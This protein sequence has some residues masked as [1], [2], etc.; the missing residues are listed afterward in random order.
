MTPSIDD[1]ELRLEELGEEAA[2]SRKLE[3]AGTVSAWVGGGLFILWMLGQ[4][5]PGIG[6]LA[7]S[8]AL[9][10]GGLVLAGSSRSTT[11]RLEAEA[12]ELTRLRTAAIDGLHLRA[13]PPR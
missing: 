12:A 4:L 7:A 6:G 3:L 5:G 10:L 11:Q 1:L 8:T 13:V 9:G 2:G